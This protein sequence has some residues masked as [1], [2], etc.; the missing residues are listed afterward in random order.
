MENAN[1]KYPTNTSDGQI[2]QTQVPKKDRP[3]LLLTTLFFLLA[4]LDN[5][6]W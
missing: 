6:S 5:G 2:R 3:E 1:A 4:L